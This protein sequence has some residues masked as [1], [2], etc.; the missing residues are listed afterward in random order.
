MKTM[1]NLRLHK[2]ENGWIVTV[3]GEAGTAFSEQTF[4]VPDGED[5][6]QYIAAAITAGRITTAAKVDE[7]AL[8]RARETNAGAAGLSGY[9][10]QQMFEKYGL[11]GTSAIF[12]GYNA[13]MAGAAAT[14]AITSDTPD[15]IARKQS[16]L[17]RLF[18]K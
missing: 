9:Y 6:G 5:L 16:L 1:Y 4:L 8:L 12:Q 11:S 3:H 10:N 15:D 18:S 7:T 13:N 14:A 17:G 2:A